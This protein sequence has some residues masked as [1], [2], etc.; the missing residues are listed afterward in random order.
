MN[1]P[2]DLD[3]AELADSSPDFDDGLESLITPEMTKQ[4][5]SESYEL[6]EA[7]ENALLSLEK[8]PA[9]ENLLDVVF[10]SI[11]SFK[12]NSGFMGLSDLE[13]MSHHIDY[14]RA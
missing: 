7:A 5:V 9:D 2:I 1:E 13:K 12:G 4:Y 14:R 10:R 6:I 3:N 11:H 8:T